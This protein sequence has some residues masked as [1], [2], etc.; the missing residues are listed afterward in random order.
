MAKKKPAPSRKSE[1]EGTEK[2]M[3]VRLTLPP[4]MHK[5]FRAIAQQEGRSMSNMA[6]R[7]VEECIAK[8]KAAGK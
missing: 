6:R 3:L 7:L 4:A 8:R 5:E 2:A 1:A